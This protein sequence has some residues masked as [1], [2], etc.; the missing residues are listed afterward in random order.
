[1]ETVFA[2]VVPVWVGDNHQTDW[3]LGTGA[4]QLVGIQGLIPGIRR[5]RVLDKE[6]SLVMRTGRL[7]DFRMSLHETFVLYLLF[8]ACVFV[9]VGGGE[10]G[11]LVIVEFTL[12][13]RVTMRC[14][15]F[16]VFWITNIIFFYFVK[17]YVTSRY[18]ANHV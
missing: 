4:A 16:K 7:E 13:I 5:H 1:M 11:V 15:N 6:W 18:F 17:F 12:W 14:E 8:C 2:V 3:I 10:G 9:V